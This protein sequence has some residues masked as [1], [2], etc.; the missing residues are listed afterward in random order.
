MNINTNVENILNKIANISGGHPPAFDDDGRCVLEIQDISI[1][2][3]A[4]AQSNSCLF[5]TIVHRGTP[6][7]ELLREALAGNLYW[8]KTKGATLMWENSS[9]A[10]ILCLEKASETLDFQ[11]FTESL[12]NFHAAAHEWLEICQRVQEE[13]KNPIA[14]R[15]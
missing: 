10:L 2:L 14:N 3:E 11:S 6:S 4:P 9:N 1:L 13:S 5:M 12:S 7:T 8:N 15:K